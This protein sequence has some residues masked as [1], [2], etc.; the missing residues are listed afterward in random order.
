MVETRT[1]RRPRRS[2]KRNPGWF[3]AGPDPRR[4]GYQFTSQD[5]KKAFQTTLERYP[6][7]GL[8][9]WIRVKRDACGK[10]GAA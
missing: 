2:R 3:K 10:R 7:K 8:W 4:S 5:R 1:P 9:L 6:E